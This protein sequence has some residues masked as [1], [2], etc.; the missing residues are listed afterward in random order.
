LR[1]R[2][3]P[4][5]TIP[6]GHHPGVRAGPAAGYGRDHR[7]GDRGGGW[8]AVQ[9][10]PGRAA[11]RCPAYDRAGGLRRLRSRAAETEV[12]FPTLA[13]ELGGEAIRRAP[14]LAGSRWPRSGPAFGAGPAAGMGVRA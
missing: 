4:G 1:H 5:P 2:D 10:A 6:C 7:R 12:A 14:A 13:V 3:T 11:G 9:G 8:R